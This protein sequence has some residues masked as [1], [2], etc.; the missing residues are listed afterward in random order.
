MANF[1]ERNREVLQL[2]HNSEIVFTQGNRKLFNRLRENKPISML[3]LPLSLL[4]GV[5]LCLLGGFLLLIAIA[6]TQRLKIEGSPEIALV[7]AVGLLLFG[8]GLLFGAANYADRMTRLWREGVLLIGEVT[9]VK[10]EWGKDSDGDP[11]TRFHMSYRFDP[12]NG[13]AIFGKHTH[14]VAGHSQEDYSDKKFLML[15][16]S[17]RD[18]LMF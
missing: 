10:R 1:A 18:T 9:N 17:E 8:L 6:P 3:D 13:D 5:F 11:E 2:L 14:A 15:Y 4:V 7:F 12:P 16:R